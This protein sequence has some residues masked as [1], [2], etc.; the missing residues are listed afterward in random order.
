MKLT[1]HHETIYEYLRARYPNAYG[2][3]QNAILATG[4][5]Y[6]SIA[7]Y[8]AFVLYAWVQEYNRLDANIL[9]IGTLLGFSAAVMAS[10]APLAKITTLNPDGREMKRARENLRRYPKVTV[11][12]AKSWEYLAKHKGEYDV[13]FVDGDHK[14][15][16]LDL[17]WWDRLRT[18]GLMI[19]HDYS[20]D[21]TPR[22]CPP[23]FA[24]VNQMAR[25]MLRTE[26]DTFVIDQDGVGMAGFYNVIG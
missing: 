10:A 19:F 14:H 15:I 9:E 18:G 13:I 8:Q 22:A 6:N 2:R 4:L 3:I 1:A 11:L 7:D 23:V 25:D 17:P 24:A 5:G 21:G 26:P 12:K 20:P 16:T